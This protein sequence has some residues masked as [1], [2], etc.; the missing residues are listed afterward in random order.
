MQS[1]T[2]MFLGWSNH[3]VNKRPIYIRQLSD[4]KIKPVVSVVKSMN[5]FSYAD[6]CGQALATAHSRSGDAVI[7]SGYMGES[8]GFADAIAE[9]SL[10]YAEQNDRD[11]EAMVALSSR[12]PSPAPWPRNMAMK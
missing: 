10:T 4:A 5:L 11:Y 8:S 2:D 1:A 9:F 7:L 3:E 12:W 6:I